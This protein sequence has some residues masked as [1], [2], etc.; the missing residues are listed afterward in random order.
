MELAVSMKNIVKRFPGGVVANNGIDLDVKKGEIHVLLGENGAG[1]STLMNILYGLYSQDEGQVLINGKEVHFNSPKDA[2]EAGIGMVH[3]HFMLIPTLTVAENIVLGSE[4]CKKGLLDTKKAISDTFNISEKYGLKVDPYA[5][6]M[7]LSVGI[8]QR[9]EILKTLYKKAEIIVLDEPTAVLTPQEV[10]ELFTIL[11]KLKDDGHTIIFITHKLKEIKDISD[12]VTV[13]R[14]G[15]S[16]KTV[17]TSDVC[18]ESLANMMVGR[19]VELRQTKPE[20]EKGEVILKV[21]DLHC[22]NKRG[23]PS[24][25]GVSFELRQ[26]EI[27]GIAGVDGNGQTELIEAITG[28]RKPTSGEVYLK[29]ENIT[30]LNSK[31]LFSKGLAHIPEDRH[32]HGLV[33]DFSI[34]ENLLLGNIENKEFSKGALINYERASKVAN[35]LVDK[36]SIKT[37]GIRS[38]ACTLS[39]GNQQKVI[40][41]RELY[42]D[43]DF[44]IA[45]Q[46]TR[47][48]DVGAIEFIHKQMLEERQ[49]GK[50]VLLV[51]MELE[52]IMD[53]SDRIL[54]IYNGKFVGELD[55]KEAT[56]E[57][58]GLLMAGVDCN[59][60]K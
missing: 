33:I 12:R 10:E 47:G 21:K 26:G 52:E 20:V 38:K 29:G 53:L 34:T 35:E 44:L 37:S 25:K 43:P 57:K 19:E 58:L 32:K 28:L 55:S 6:V 49:K 13:I 11:H 31:E 45:A 60:K 56:M 3:Q 36:F 51:S 46:P 48:I 14:D 41:A 1:K 17:S 9:I 59:E 4:P 40:V 5:K 24:L 22:N 8:Q 15:Q 27:L 7:D 18:Q 23:I 30:G 2:V 16:I 42:R 50:A 39:G 54:V